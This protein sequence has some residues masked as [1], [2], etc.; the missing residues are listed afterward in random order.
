MAPHL[1]RTLPGGSDCRPEVPVPRSTD[2]LLSCFV[3]TFC[4]AGLRPGRRSILAG[5]ERYAASCVWV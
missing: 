1:A 2:R 4:G 5:A 3:E